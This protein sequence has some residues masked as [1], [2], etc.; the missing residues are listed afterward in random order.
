MIAELPVA[1]PAQILFVIPPADE[2][3]FAS[4]VPY[5]EQ[6]NVRRLLRTLQVIHQADN[7]SQCCERLAAQFATRADTQGKR[8]LSAKRLKTLYYEY[9]GGCTKGGVTYRAGDWRILLNKAKAPLEKQGLPAQFLEFWRKLCE[10]HQRVSSEALRELHHIFRTKF[11]LDGKRRYT[12]I[13]GYATWPEADENTGVPAGWGKNLYRHAPDKLELAASRIGRKAASEF[14]LKVRNTRVGLK[15]GEFMEFDD[16]EFNLLVNFPGQWKAMRPRGFGVVDV[17][18]GCCFSHILK[19]TLWDDDEKK[20]KALTETDFMWFVVN[21]LMHTGFRTDDVGTTL[22]VEHGTAAIRGNKKYPLG[23]AL[24][25]DLEQRLYDATGG[26]VKV[27]RSGLY[28]HPAHQGQ[29]ASEGGGNYRFKAHVEGFWRMVDDRLDSL[30]GQVGKG[31]D[32]SPEQLL[33]IRAMNTKLLEA[34]QELPPERAAHL[35]FPVMLWHDCA[36][37]IAAGIERINSDPEHKLEGWER[38]GFMVQQWRKH[39]GADWLPA[40][41]WQ[42]LSEGERMMLAPTVRSNPMLFSQRRMARR[43]VFTSLYSGFGR[44][45]LEQIPGLVGQ[46]NAL[47]GGDTLTVR[48]GEFEFEDWRMGPEPFRYIAQG[49]QGRF[50]EGEKFVCFVNPLNPTA[51]IACD[52]RLRVIAVCPPVDVACRND[53]EQSLRNIGKA[54]HHFAQALAPLNERHAEEGK[55]IEFMKRHNEAV[56]KGA[57]VT[58]EEKDR[59]RQIRK[60]VRN[61]DAEDMQAIFGTSEKVPTQEETTVTMPMD[62]EDE[63]VLSILGGTDKELDHD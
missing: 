21:T 38:L 55:A 31:R 59:A 14:K 23:H 47:R 36:Q 11:S 2:T 48:E 45:A 32:H 20:K 44:L 17:L 39:L 28:G 6:T 27:E 40:A 54:S 46:H 7:R 30:P 34:A 63:D 41:E 57:P 5:E 12:E 9:I 19:P 52:A 29:H 8:G 33:G 10:N 22:I 61:V 50:K 26:K 3:T 4:E 43:E 53:R 37:Q 1:Q 16:H 42:K 62:D 25:Q 51:L 58:E 24:R 60:N 56:I 13:P 18:S 35:M 15:L 49:A